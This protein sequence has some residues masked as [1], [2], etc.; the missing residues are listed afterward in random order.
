V[1]KKSQKRLKIR[2]FRFFYIIGWIINYCITHWT[3]PAVLSRLNP[4]II[5]GGKCTLPK[6]DTYEYFTQNNS[7]A[8]KYFVAYTK[9]PKD[10]PWNKTKELLI[11]FDNKKIILKPDIGLRSIGVMATDNEDKIKALLE[12]G[13]VDYIIQE[14]INYKYELGVFYYKYPTWKKGKIM[15]IAQRD[16][17]D[18]VDPH[19][20]DQYTTREDLITPQVLTIFN[21]IAGDKEIYFCRFDVRAKSLEDFKKGQFKILEANVGP[22]AVALHA[23]DKNYSWKKQLKLYSEEYVHAFNIAELN[24]N[25]PKTNFMKYLFFIIQDDIKLRLLK[26]RVRKII[27]KEK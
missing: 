7:L 23:L 3:N 24:K 25:A 1:N 18:I 27:T 21:K 12:V 4:R 6:S 10:S 5:N 8:K 14:Y 22:D 26:W 19:N 15:G 13:K 2:G 20:V 16:F 9:I 11:K 17:E